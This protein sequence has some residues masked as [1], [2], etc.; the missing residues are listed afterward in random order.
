[1][2]VLST[3][4]KGIAI[5][6]IENI[7]NNYLK[8]SKDKRSFVFNDKPFFWLADTAWAAGGYVTQSEWKQ[9]VDYRSEQGF[10][11]VQI[12]ALPQY[13]TRLKPIDEYL[14]FSKNNDGTYNYD[15]IKEDYFI[16][17]SNL[18]NYA[19][20]KGLLVAIVLLW[21]DFVPNAREDLLYKA[22]P[23]SQ[24]MSLKQAKK[25]VEI[26]VSKLASANIVWIISG[27]DNFKGDG[28]INFYTDIAKYVKK[29]DKHK[30]L[31]TA[32]TGTVPG[33]YFENSNC[34]DFN[35]VQSSHGDENQDYTYKYCLAEWQK[36]N[37]KPVVNGEICYEGLKGWDAG[38]VFLPC[39]VSYAFW[40]SVL[41]GSIG[42]ITYGADGVWNFL[43]D[44]EQQVIYESPK[45]MKWYDAIKLPAA[46]ECVL[47]KE[48]LTSM[49]YEKLMPAQHL[50]LTQNKL[51]NC[52][53]CAKDASFMLVFVPTG[54]QLSLNLNQ[55]SKNALISE[56]C[57]RTYSKKTIGYV[58]DYKTSSNLYNFNIKTACLLEIK[59]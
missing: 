1:M 41:S 50:I 2:V 34:L 22:R 40:Q 47:A 49:P 42:G 4:K 52:C 10:N 16:R 26:L 38:H 8:V 13:E 6:M 17:L 58:K 5:F 24:R 53:A 29:I 20:E 57:L 19:N 14:P 30:R 48:Y 56:I 55:F 39:D 15:D 59:D 9:Y 31:I 7:N 37:I 54:G 44:G 51:H 46:N 18:V 28:V 21:Y 32:H 36:Q 3:S 11:A 23:M 43:K 35:M 25:Y 12:C 33:E 45:Q 27:D